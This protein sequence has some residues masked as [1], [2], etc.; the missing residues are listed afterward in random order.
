MKNYNE[1]I[2]SVFDRIG[3]YETEK[4]RKRKIIV[5]AVTSFSCC[6]LVALLGVGVF[7]MG[8][9]KSEPDY[10]ENESI[11]AS[12]EANSSGTNSEENASGA[13]SETDTNGSADVSKP[14]KPSAD[15]VI[16]GNDNGSEAYIERH[17]KSVSITLD[18]VLSNEAKPNDLIAIRVSFRL[19]DDF[20]YNN[21]TLGEFS[22]E[23]SKESALIKRMSYLTEYGD[24]L[25]Y[26]EALYETG[27]PNGEKWAKNLYFSIIERI[28][29]D[30]ISKYI[31]DGEFLKEDLERDLDDLENSSPCRYAY[32]KAK[33]VCYENSSK[34][35]K[36]F[37]EEKNI[38]CEIQNGNSIVFFTSADK[39]DEISL[40]NAAIYSLATND[41]SECE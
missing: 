16:W 40:E 32:E 5:K 11:A 27:A 19:Y 35:A 30:L 34:V 3:E 13:N 33:M 15:S 20:V 28:G 1:T 14:S 29:E 23:Y 17:E 10:A 12:S 38:Y 26:G 25:K 18:E 37:L 21:K 24:S 4:K 6:C 41:F 36:V 39:F 31:V 2:K 22:M 9:F 7:Q 8:L